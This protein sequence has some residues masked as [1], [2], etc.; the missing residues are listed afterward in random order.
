[1]RL[2]GEAAKKGLVLCRPC[3]KKFS[4]T[5][6]TVLERSHI[7]LTKWLMGFRLMAASKK[8]V[9]AL[10]MHRMMGITY[11]T[12]WFLNHRIR[13]AMDLIPR[14]PVPSAAKAR[15]SK[16]TKPTSAA[17]RRPHTRAS[18]FLKSMPSSL[19]SNVTVKSA[20]TTLPRQQAHDPRRAHQERQSQVNADD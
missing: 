1:M 19:L 4:V 7:P 12:A 20:P 9:S 5:V 6:G 3:R 11:K 14:N 15:S 8:G 2:G 13:K 16:A 18:P 17:R 10:Q